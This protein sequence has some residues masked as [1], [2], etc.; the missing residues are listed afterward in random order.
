MIW[1]INGTDYAV[2]IYPLKKAKRV[3][4][5]KKSAYH[6]AIRAPRH[7]PVASL[8]TLFQTQLSLF[9]D[10]P[11]PL[12]YNAYLNQDIIQLWGEETD[13][14][15]G[16]PVQEKID[17]LDQMMLEELSYIEIYYKK[18]QDI[19]DLNHLSYQV[20]KYES[21]FGSC[22]PRKRIIR[23]NRLLVHYPKQ[24]LEYIYAHEIVHLNIPHHQAAFYQCL[25]IIEP[26]HVQLKKALH[27]Y[28]QMFTRS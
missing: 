28:H 3:T 10:L 16:L 6:Y 12:D 21:K 27:H 14:F 19:I 15:K 4:V 9:D 11:V 25:D 26:D 20:K 22:H 5:R 23:F 24:Y 7:V 2:D 1:S 18:T 8:K 17:R 13:L